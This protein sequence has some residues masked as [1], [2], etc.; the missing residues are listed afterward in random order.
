MGTYFLERWKEV[1]F[2]LTGDILSIKSSICVLYNSR[3]E[4]LAPAYLR[5]DSHTPQCAHI[6]TFVHV[7]CSVF[8]VILGVLFSLIMQE[9]KSSPILAHSSNPS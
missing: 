4:P 5:D 6:L 1:V 2:I 7:Y 8:Y 3:I 9:I